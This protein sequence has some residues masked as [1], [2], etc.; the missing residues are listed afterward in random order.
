MS[1][2]PSKQSSQCG[3]PFSHWTCCQCSSSNPGG[4]HVCRGLLPFQDDDY[5]TP[6]NHWHCPSCHGNSDNPPTVTN[7][8]NPPP[9]TTTTTT[10]TTTGDSYLN[11]NN[12]NNTTYPT[13]PP[14]NHS[15]D[16]RDSHSHSHPPPTNFSYTTAYLQSAAARRRR[17]GTLTFAQAFPAPTSLPSTDPVPS[18]TNL[19]LDYSAGGGRLAAAADDDD[20]DEDNVGDGYMY[21]DGDGGGDDDDGG[22]RGYWGVDDGNKDCETRKRKAE[23]AEEEER[24]AVGDGKRRR[25]KGK[26]KAGCATG[27]GTGGGGGWGQSD[28]YPGGYQPASVED[29]I[30]V[31]EG[32]TRF[33]PPVEQDATSAPPTKTAAK[34]QLASGSPS[35]DTGNVSHTSLKPPKVFP[36]H[37]MFPLPP[38]VSSSDVPDFVLRMRKG[39]RTGGKTGR[40]TGENQV[41]GPSDHAEL[42]FSPESVTTTDNAPPSMPP[43]PSTPMILKH[44][45]SGHAMSKLTDLLASMKTPA[46]PAQAKPESS[47]MAPKKTTTERTRSSKKPAP[48]ELQRHTYYSTARTSVI[49]TGNPFSLLEE[50]LGDE[51]DETLGDEEEDRDELF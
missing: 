30:D 22:R 24:G 44:A 35:V 41:D 42:T 28:C 10:T 33:P 45:R 31:E 36:V 5:D 34:Q 4:R 51:E 38:P 21:C 39:R 27:S 3:M 18:L 12:N 7:S 46:S 37:G 20:G 26:G 19:R 9:S 6:C 16:N 25:D 40:R 14:P 29:G 49:P 11:N 48:R 47:P 1:V 50:T 8:G 32:R 23:D 17:P 43:T 2:K 15:H 13:H